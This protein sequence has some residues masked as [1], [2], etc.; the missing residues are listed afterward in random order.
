MSE[1]NPSASAMKE[2]RGTLILSDNVYK[3]IDGKWV[4]SGTYNRWF[5]PKDV[6][7]IH[8]INTYIRLLFEQLGVYS[9][10]IT[11]IAKEASPAADPIL[12]IPFEITV[13]AECLPVYEMA[14]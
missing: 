12:E 6:L 5:T 8:G 2:I 13:T 9:G 11:V 1:S 14:I 3:T 10:T 7:T 4:I